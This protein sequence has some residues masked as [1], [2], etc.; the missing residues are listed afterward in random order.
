MIL[1]SGGLGVLVVFTC[2]FVTFNSEEFDSILGNLIY[3]PSDFWEYMKSTPE[4]LIGMLAEEIDAL[5]AERDSAQYLK[6]PA[7]QFRP[8]N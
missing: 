1:N 3:A 7:S 8:P 6:P 4:S 2:L 5:N